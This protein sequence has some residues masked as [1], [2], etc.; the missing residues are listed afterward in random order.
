MYMLCS[1]NYRLNF[2]KLN[3]G[4][5][6]SAYDHNPTFYLLIKNNNKKL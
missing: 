5:D 3:F 2:L 6:N 1:F 4:N